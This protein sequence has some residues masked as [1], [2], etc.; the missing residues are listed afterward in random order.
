MRAKE[1]LMSTV[2]DLPATPA[3]RGYADD[4]AVSYG[5]NLGQFV[6]QFNDRTGKSLDSHSV[7]RLVAKLAK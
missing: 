1:Y 2:T 7:W 3:M 5:I 6:Q 4:P